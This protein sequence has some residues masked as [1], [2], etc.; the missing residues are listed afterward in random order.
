MNED[1]AY[2]QPSGAIKQF[3]L[4]FHAMPYVDLNNEEL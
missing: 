1:I 2:S 4:E 3:F